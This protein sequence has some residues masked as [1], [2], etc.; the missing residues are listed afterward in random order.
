[1]YIKQNGWRKNAQSIVKRY[2]DE[3]LRDRAVT[4]DFNWGV[5]VPLEGYE[6]K[7]IFVWIEAV[8]GYLTASIKCLEERNEDWREYWQGDDS[9]IYFVH[10]KDNIPFHTVIFPAILVGLGIK[11]PNLRIISSEYLKLEGKSFSAAKNWAIWADYIAKNYN[12]DSFRYYLALNSPE[13]RDADFTWR[14]YINV[15]NYDLA[16]NL[17]G[18]TSKVIS[19][20]NKKYNGR[21]PSGKISKELKEEMFNL[22]FQVGDNIEEGYF[23]EALTLVMNFCKKYRKYFDSANVWAL[24]N[25]N[26][27]KCSEVIYNCI[28]I[29]V[30]LSNLLEPFIPNTCEKIRKSLKIEE[31]IWSYIEQNNV[32]IDEI[33][34]LF[35]K[36]DKKRAMKE[37]NILKEKRT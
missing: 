35:N 4:R 1:M 34:I 37:V 3:G 24:I 20:V 21:I 12:I 25:T 6:D 33:A 23:K 2:L 36:I 32:R 8:M 19:F 9:R 5:H 31:P 15:N 10:G 14:D 16:A 26:P 22:Y 28:Q 7:R 13:E 17:G 11:N 27:A 30:N 18:F 29:I